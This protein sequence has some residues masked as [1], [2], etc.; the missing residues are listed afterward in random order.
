MTPGAFVRVLFPTHEK[1]SQ[2]GLLRIGYVLVGNAAEV[3]VAYTTS[4][5]WPTSMPFPA[6]ARLFDTEEAAA[7]NQARAFMLR[8]DVLAKMPR[9]KAWFPDID[10][11]DKGVIAVASPQ[12]RDELTELATQLARR[13]RALIQMRG[14]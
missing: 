8:L 14:V 10:R 1:P 13:R 12:L 4:Q 11:P 3:M 9:T 6:G 2:P 5:P 7:L